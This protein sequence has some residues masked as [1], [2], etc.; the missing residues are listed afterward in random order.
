MFHSLVG[1]DLQLPHLYL[2]MSNVNVAGAV[3]DAYLMVIFSVPSL[4]MR[5]HRAVWSGS[6]LDLV[7]LPPTNNSDSSE[8]R[9]AMMK[10]L[11]P[12]RFG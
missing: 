9:T 7:L 1:P 2:G 12:S 6:G 8:F 5:G 4:I 3:Q 11:L 10:W